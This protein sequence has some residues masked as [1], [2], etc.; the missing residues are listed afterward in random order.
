[1]TV[2]AGAVVELEADA[3]LSVALARMAGAN[4]RWK[5]LATKSREKMPRY[6]HRTSGCGS[7][8]CSGLTPLFFWSDGVL[9]GGVKFDTA[10]HPSF[11]T[12]TGDR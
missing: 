7:T 12:G 9:H 10:S 5:R 2:S 11:R 3:G 1:M 8:A 6:G 4:E